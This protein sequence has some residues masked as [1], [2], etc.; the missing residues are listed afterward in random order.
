MAANKVTL[1]NITLQGGT[2][3][4]AFVTWTY[5]SDSKKPA[6]KFE[7][8]WRYATGQKRGK[9]L[10][11]F[12]GSTGSV[13]LNAP[14]NCTYSI[15]ENA[16][17]IFVRV[18][19]VSKTK[20]KNNSQ[21]YFT[22]SWVTKTKD[23]KN[24]EVIPETPSAPNVSIEKNR[25][26][27]SLDSYDSNT[28]QV[29]FEIVIDNSKRYG[30]I[31][32][33]DLVTAHAALTITVE[34]GH[35]YKVRAQGVNNTQS[36]AKTSA[37][38]NYS[39]E[40][41]SLP[42]APTGLKAEAKT[43]NSIEVSW[44]AVAN[45]TEYELQWATD[46]K[47]FDAN[48]ER[49]SSYTAETGATTYLMDQVEETGKTYYFR[50]R[51]NAKDAEDFSDWS[52][53]VEATVGTVPNAPTTW[54]M[55]STAK[56]GDI[57][58]LYWTHNSEDGSEMDS[59]QIELI[60]NGVKSTV[61]YPNTKK[62]TDD[63]TGTYM[64]TI[65]TSTY[66]LGSVLKWKVRTKGVLTEP[67]SGYGEWS[68]ERQ[69]D[70]YARPTL[71]IEIGTN[72]AWNWDD[73]DLQN[74]DI[75]ETPG[76]V[77]PFT[78]DTVTAFPIYILLES[79]PSMQTPIGYYISIVSSEDNEP[80]DDTTKTGENVHV[81]PG[82]EIFSRYYP[83]KSHMFAT[84]LTASDINL[85]DVMDYKI[86]ATVSMDSGLTAETTL[87]FSVDWD[88]AEFELDAGLGYD[89]DNL[90]MNIIPQAY[91]VNEQ[92]EEEPIEDAL[93]SVYRIDA[94]GK[95]IE[96]MANLVSSGDVTV[97]DPHPTFGLAKYRIVGMSS[98]T[99]AVQFADVTIDVP[100]TSIVIQWD[101]EWESFNDDTE[102]D[103]AADRPWYG[104]MLRLPYNID[105]SDS[106]D[107]DVE[108]AEYI[109][110]A[111]PVS[112]YG[113][114]LGQK[115]SWKT[116]IPTSDTETITL[117]RRLRVYMGDVYVRE[118]YGTGYWAQVKVQFE[119]KHNSVVTPV[120][121]EVTRVEGGM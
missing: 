9:D 4:T 59:A 85:A 102:N 61:D 68:I 28:K 12:Q 47:Y 48:L 6:E 69:I 80:Y 63:D 88:E 110:R 99:G 55:T 38:S 8:E 116:D 54:S 92:D 82:Q 15:P 31:Q 64:Y 79:G 1:G 103:I 74:G 106:N 114:Q 49:V 46:R 35:S 83:R 11:W 44:N 119:L 37:W 17:S 107:V 75:N 24:I 36:K 93:L 30:R 41:H 112:Y 90:T 62:G 117:L 57:L 25:L 118:P 3:S 2:D 20:G 34:A 67:D 58:Y 33:V 16:G 52:S 19:P 97:V 101:E 39:S 23:V 26:S 56:V 14:R 121:L 94:D 72:F 87:D 29:N 71:N 53:I 70:I 60:L 21:T 51:A 65:D 108:F 5:K 84:M 76:V 86:I 98:A 111:H 7:Y 100:E 96:I 66:E 73:F 77:T 95:F 78:D 115:S 81:I 42:V 105:I 18:R 13:E 113:T 22:P 50:V 32:T 10:I 27:M 109:G 120:T 104:T 91:T 45:A 40:V 43:K 89:P